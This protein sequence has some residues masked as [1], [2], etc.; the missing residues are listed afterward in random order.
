M[1]LYA[2]IDSTHVIA[3]NFK[4]RLSGVTSTV[5]QLVPKQ[6]EMGVKIAS[7]A[8]EGLPESVVCVRFRDLWR[9]WL[10]PEGASHRV[11]HARRNTEMLPGIILRDVLRMKIRLLFTSD[12]QRD[13]RRYTKWLI[14]KMDAVIAGS[15]QATSYLNVPS[16]IVMHGINTA[17]FMPP[18]DK[19]KAKQ[20][21]GFDPAVR[22][23]GCFGRIRSQKGTDRFV[24]AMIALLPANPQWAA[25]VTG[26]VTADNEEFADGLKAEIAAAGLADRIRFAGEVEDITL[27]YQALDLFVAPQRWEGF[28]LTPLE[29]MACGIPVAAT[30]VGAFKELIVEGVNGMVADNDDAA[31]SAAIGKMMTDDHM[32]TAMAANCRDHVVGGFM[33]EREARQINAIYDQLLKS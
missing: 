18:A 14:G 3:P 29:A 10:K 28:G 30:A 7:L 13:H 31:I 25:V 8:P 17:Q 27:W 6:R 32:R 24:R 1:R 16:S 19:S 15:A 21:I 23:V 33:L 11:W 4:K 26:R 5:L 2:N 20:A 22:L 9:L 12:A